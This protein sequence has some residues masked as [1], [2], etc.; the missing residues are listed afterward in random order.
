MR[1][2]INYTVMPWMDGVIIGYI[3][4]FALAVLVAYS[5]FEFFFKRRNLT[6]RRG[7]LAMITN[8]IWAL[9]LNL[10]VFSIAYWRWALIIAAVLSLLFISI[11]RHELKVAYDDELG[12]RRGLFPAIRTIRGEEFADLSVEE[13]MAYKKTVKPYRFYWYFFLPITVL[14]PFCAVLM[15]DLL[16]VGD[17]LFEVYYFP[18]PSI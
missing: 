10:C 12:G 5:I 7:T 13:Q 15:L 6:M 11:I 14:L 17:Y 18:V 16:G 9:M 3:V 8:T 2:P 1:A 4:P